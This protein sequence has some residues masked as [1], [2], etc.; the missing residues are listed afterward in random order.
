MGPNALLNN[1]TGGGNT[2]VGDNALDH[3]TVGVGNLAL[4]NSSG[5]D[6]TT[7]SGVICI[8]HNGANRDNTTWIGNVYG[9]NN[10]IGTTAPVVVSS[11]G[12]LGTVAS[13]QRFKKDIATMEKTS[14][15]ILSLRPV[16]FHYKTDTEG[17]LQFGLIAEESRKGESGAGVA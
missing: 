11:T 1:T 5:V 14:E 17:I 9:V 13:S 10:L 15:A 6:A 7:A 8:G 3:C 2:A 12:Q 16:T 4:G